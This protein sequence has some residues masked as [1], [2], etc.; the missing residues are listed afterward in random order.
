[1]KRTTILLTVITAMTAAFSK[2]D[3]TSANKKWCDDYIRPLRDTICETA[4]KGGPIGT[5]SYPACRIADK[6]YKEGCSDSYTP[7]TPS[8]SGRRGTAYRAD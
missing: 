5:F 8:N 1:M 3:D 4:T 6:A 2:A 7:Y